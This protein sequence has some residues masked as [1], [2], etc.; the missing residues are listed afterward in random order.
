MKNRSDPRNGYLSVNIWLWGDFRSPSA[1]KWLCGGDQPGTEHGPA[2]GPAAKNTQRHK[3][4]HHEEAE[5]GSVLLGTIG[6]HHLL[7]VPQSQH[8]PRTSG[9]KIRYR[10]S[11]WFWFSV[12]PV[13]AAGTDCRPDQCCALKFELSGQFFSSRN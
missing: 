4:H 10:A 11:C 6:C 9:S 1:A 3:V 2:L 13:S 8:H 12:G 5:I 7:K